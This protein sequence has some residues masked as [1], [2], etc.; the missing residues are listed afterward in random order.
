MLYSK[1]GLNRNPLHAHG[2]GFVA[3]QTLDNCGQRGVGK[4][5]SLDNVHKRIIDAVGGDAV[6]VG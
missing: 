3:T 2:E 5:G 1:C 6:A 4:I